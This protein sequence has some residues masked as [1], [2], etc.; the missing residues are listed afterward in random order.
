MREAAAAAAAAASS[1]VCAMAGGGL[2]L[3]NTYPA[4]IEQAGRRVPVCLLGLRQKK[5]QGERD[6]GSL[7]LSQRP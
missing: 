4:A 6:S 2:S 1:I 5:Q 7:Q 3:R